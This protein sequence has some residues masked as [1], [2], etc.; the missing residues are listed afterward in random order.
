M[1]GA[2]TQRC[3]QQRQGSL[4]ASVGYLSFCPLQGPR[5]FWKLICRIFLSLGFYKMFYLDLSH[6]S[7]WFHDNQVKNL[8]NNITK[9]C[10]TLHIAKYLM[11]LICPITWLFEL[12]DIYWG[13]F[14]VVTLFPYVINKDFVERCF[15]TM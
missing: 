3:E 8:S 15:K 7:L 12:S 11:N 9:T 2:I 13:L 4:W 5:H 14:T 6:V 10:W 1:E